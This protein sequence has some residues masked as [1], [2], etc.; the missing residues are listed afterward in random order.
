MALTT[1]P[2]TPPPA[3]HPPAQA[4]RDGKQLVMRDGGTTPPRCVKCNAAVYGLPL[5]VK[6]QLRKE[7]DYDQ[8]PSKAVQTAQVLELLAGTKLTMPP[9]RRATVKVFV[10]GAHR[11]N[12]HKMVIGGF[13][14]GLGIV[15]SV[16]CG[17]FGM[18]AEHGEAF[19][20]GGIASFMIS[21]F[22]GVLFLLPIVRPQTIKNG[23]A[24]MKG[25]GLPF[26]QSLGQW[27][28]ESQE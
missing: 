19:S 21:L 24:W 6:L 1:K 23:V 9:L 26:L 11:P 7:G 13:I 22:V 15:V 17:V 3:V 16:A 10:C 2:S 4:W 27:K 25:A 14:L 28:G 12:P 5:L 8:N 20:I 18:R